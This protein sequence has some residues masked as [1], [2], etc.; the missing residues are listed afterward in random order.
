MDDIIKEV[1]SANNNRCNVLCDLITSMLTGDPKGK[2]NCAYL[3]S[4]LNVTT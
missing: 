4:K 3:I 2:K 1:K